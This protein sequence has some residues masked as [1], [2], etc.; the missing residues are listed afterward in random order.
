MADNDA[1]MAG[2]GGDFADPAKGPGD[3]PRAMPGGAPPGGQLPGHPPVHPVPGPIPVPAHPPADPLRPGPA[4]RPG[5]AQA[6]DGSAIT[7]TTTAGGTITAAGSEGRRMV[8]KPLPPT[9][10]GVVVR[11]MQ[12][13]FMTQGQSP[14]LTIDR[15]IDETN[16]VASAGFAGGGSQIT[17]AIT[18][19]S[20]TAGT[21]KASGSYGATPFKWAGPVDL[22][23]NPVPT[24][25]AEGFNSNA[26]AT[27]IAQAS[28]FSPACEEI[29]AAPPA[30]ATAAP[31]PAPTESWG[32]FLGKAFVWGAAGV[33][34]TF[35]TGGADLLVLAG[36]FLAGADASMYSDL[37]TEYA[38]QN[39]QIPAGQDPLPPGPDPSPDPTPDPVPA[40]PGPGPGDDG[41]DDGGGCFAV[42]TLVAT[43]DGR[44]RPI[45]EVRVNDLVAARDE[46]SRADGMRRVSRT[47]THHGKDTIDLRLQTG[48]TI[49]TTS[50]HRV[51]TL[52]RG[53]VEVDGLKVGD[54]VETQSAGPQAIEDITR[55]PSS[56]TVHNLTIDGYHTYFVG[57]AGMWVHNDKKVDD[58]ESDGGADPAPSGSQ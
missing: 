18:L 1:Q 13:E 37:V 47:W 8:V 38:Q 36:A 16:K 35:L 15:S 3:V 6:A 12:M 58:G 52:E 40:E 41:G 46:L 19:T 50:V 22:S 23:A 44:C 54:H 21:G 5:S 24:L 31:A 51:F 7:W 25:A 11:A 20:A 39:P 45:E 43:G 27:Q 2:G 17:L 14:Y 28:Y 26:F 42:G 33:A 53:V 30:G 9:A 10:P 34:A 4:P 32:E 48:E 57:A 29:L 56:V 55:G 49:R